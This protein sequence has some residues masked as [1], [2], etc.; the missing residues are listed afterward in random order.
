[1]IRLAPLAVLALALSGCAPAQTPDQ[2]AWS[3]CVAFYDE[4]RPNGTVED[5]TGETY[6]SARM[7]HNMIG[8]RG[9]EAFTAFWNDPDRVAEY[10][11]GF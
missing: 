8:H 10:A 6:D 3:S 7:C 9:Q 2:T 11:R 1:M 4:H 5:K